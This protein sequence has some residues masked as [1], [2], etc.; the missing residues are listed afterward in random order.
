MDKL[1][2]GISSCLLGQEVRFDSGHKHNRY[3]TESLG[4]YFDYL[5]FCPEVAIGLGVPRPTIQLREIGSEIRVR[6]SK[7]EDFDCTDKLHQYGRDIAS[8]L[9]EVCGYLF[10]KGSPSCGM[11]RV[12]VYKDSGIPRHDGVGAFAEEIIRARPELP[13]EEEG[14]LMDPHL[15]ENFIERVFIMQRWNMES[16]GG[17]DARKLVDFHRRHKFIL[18]AHD[19]VAYRELG[20]MVA[21]AG[22]RDIHAL[23]ERYIQAMMTA[24][25]KIATPGQHTNVLMHIFGFF[26]EH[27]GKEDKKELLEIIEE[28]RQ[29]RVPLVVPITMLK[30]YLRLFPSEYIAEQYYMNPH[31]SEL[32]LRNHI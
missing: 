6:G 30:H 27:L 3:I 20:R 5:P 4:V 19:E 18:Q 23:S 22:K 17:W 13:V 1:K 11:E 9:S 14:R 7:D 15:R 28:Y 21:D 10:K 29:Q 31:P 16:S 24:L 25:K 12:K 26:K 32:M 2:I 8:Q